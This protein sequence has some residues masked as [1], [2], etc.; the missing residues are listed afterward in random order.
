M[1]FILIS[2]SSFQRPAPPSTRLYNVVK[3]SIHTI[4]RRS[5][6][7]PIRY[8]HKHFHRPIVSADRA[9][10]LIYIPALFPPPFYLIP[11]IKIE[12]A[13]IIKKIAPARAQNTY[14]LMV[15]CRSSFLFRF[16]RFRSSTACSSAV[17]RSKI[18]F[19]LYVQTFLYVIMHSSIL[20]L[21]LLAIRPLCCVPLL[22]TL[23]YRRIR[24]CTI[25]A[26]PSRLLLSV[27]DKVQ[28]YR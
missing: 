12:M 16:L 10:I 24:L 18:S 7:N 14:A 21:F 8:S 5:C 9:D 4:S 19:P 11:A 15:A 6:L 3:G 28:N 1:N 26:I 20:H 27:L 25:P 13:G 2:C 22:H 17:R 23:L